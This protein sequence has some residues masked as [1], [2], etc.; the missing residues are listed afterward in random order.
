[1]G[2]YA[3]ELPTVSAP[4][5]IQNDRGVPRLS[6]RHECRVADHSTA[7]VDIRSRGIRAY[8]TLG[9]LIRVPPP[10]S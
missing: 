2:C 10:A 6:P 1:M 9:L 8:K 3:R 5:F 7:H 4:D